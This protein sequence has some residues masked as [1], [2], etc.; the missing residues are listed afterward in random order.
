MPTKE[1]IE[2]DARERAE[3]DIA[4]A[5]AID[6]LSTVAVLILLAIIAYAILR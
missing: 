4:E 5:R 3:A 1:W 6:A 2:R